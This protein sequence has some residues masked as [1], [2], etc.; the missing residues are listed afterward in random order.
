MRQ[1]RARP[2]LLLASFAI[3]WALAVAG[4]QAQAPA[5]PPMAEEVFRNVQI[6]KGIPVDQFMG[7]MGF[8]SASLGLNCTDCHSGKQAKAKLDLAGSRSLEQLRTQ[9]HL[10]FH[11]LERVEA[12]TMP[13]KD[14]EPLK[15]AEK[16]ALP[17][18]LHRADAALLSG[19]AHCPRCR[20]RNLEPPGAREGTPCHLSTTVR[21]KRAPS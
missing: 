4:L 14:S 8:L 7:T 16:Q 2:F 19:Q 13:P 1:L 12:G 9:S 10:W 15:P 3:V 20:D 5:R 6:L 18:A 11:L 21:T 17:S